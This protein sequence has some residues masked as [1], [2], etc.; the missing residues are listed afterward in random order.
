MRARPY[1]DAGLAL[2][3]FLP[4]EWKGATPKSIH[5]ERVW[6]RLADRERMVVNDAF[7]RRGMNGK[8]LPASKRH[9]VLDAVGLGLFALGR[10]K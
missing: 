1:K 4:I 7:S 5:H 9:N 6:A 2:D 10:G 3:F 8:P